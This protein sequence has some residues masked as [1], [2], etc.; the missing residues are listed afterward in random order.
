MFI[1]NCYSRLK[2]AGIDVKRSYYKTIL[3]DTISTHITIILR[4]GASNDNITSLYIYCVCVWI[5]FIFYRM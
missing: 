5:I 2:C 3:S 1:Y 4:F